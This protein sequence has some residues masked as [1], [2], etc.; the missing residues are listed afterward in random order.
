MT[1]TSKITLA[2][3]GAAAVALAAAP[4]SATT[5][6][7]G[8]V[9]SF[10]YKNGDTYS[11]KLDPAA[12]NGNVMELSGDG[13]GC[14]GG[15]GVRSGVC[16][17]EEE[18]QTPGSPAENGDGRP[19]PASQPLPVTIYL[20]LKTAYPTPPPIYVDWLTQVTIVGSN[21]QTYHNMC[22]PGCRENM[23]L[24]THAQAPD[25]PQRWESGIFTGVGLTYF[26]L[27]NQN[28]YVSEVKFTNTNPDGVTSTATWVVNAVRQTYFHCTHCT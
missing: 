10:T 25:A 20:S 23:Q 28:V 18:G 26:Q 12:T 4:A 14:N 11:I 7:Y 15:P 8:I 1:T 5:T 17:D 22:T 3:A 19:L 16:Y 13:Q 21:G 6:D 27:P 2:V 9:H 24:I